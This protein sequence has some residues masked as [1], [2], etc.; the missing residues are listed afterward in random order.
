MYMLPRW[1][2]RLKGAEP[3]QE[4]WNREK[5]EK[6]LA[7]SAVW[8][9]EPM[10]ELSCQVKQRG[11]CIGVTVSSAGIPMKLVLTVARVCLARALVLSGPHSAVLLSSVCRCAMRFKIHS[12][13]HSP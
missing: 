10:I 8:G 4:A 2:R 5:K 9:Q 13:I 3:I 12:F 11:M 6:T 1:L 7:P